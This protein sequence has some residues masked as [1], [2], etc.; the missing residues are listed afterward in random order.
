MIINSFNNAINVR[1]N[2]KVNEN[3]NNVMEIIIGFIYYLPY[4]F[5]EL[6]NDVII[7]L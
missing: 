3:T 2:I 4:N 6:F 7:V 1:E 5:I